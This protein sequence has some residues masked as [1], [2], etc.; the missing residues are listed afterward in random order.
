MIKISKPWIEIENNMV[1]L[2]AEIEIPEEAVD[3]WKDFSKK[4]HYYTY[5][6]S[7]YKIE[8]NKFI[9]WYKVD[10]SLK[11]SFC[12][13]R[14][15]AFLVAI[16]YYAMITGQD[17]ISD[18]CISN[19]L[20]FNLNYILIPTL[21]NE[22][23]GYK[24]IFINSEITKKTYESE[25]NFVATGMSAG[26]DSLYTLYSLKQDYVKEDYKINM[27][28]FI[29]AGA[30]HYCP[31]LPK[32]TKLDKI[33]KEAERIHREK[34]ER[35]KKIADEE[36]LNLMNIESNISDLYQGQFGVTHIYR[37]MSCI[38]AMQKVFRKY[39]Y[40]SAGLSIESYKP[41]LKM[42]PAYM[43]Q[44]IIPIL[45]TENLEVICGGESRTRYTKTKE[46]CNYS[47][48]QNNLNVCG[49]EMN[50]TACTK[51]YRT[52]LTL[53]QLGKLNEFSKVFDLKKYQRNRI[54][55]YIWLLNNSKKDDFAEDIYNHM[56]I[57][58]NIPLKAKLLA[59]I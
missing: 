17:V 56:K 45:S 11:D 6:K 49:K 31:Y 1:Y 37:N 19:K 48:A 5:I 36:K 8:N 21:C 52:L 12:D 28:T 41:D 2:K 23:S 26:I 22:Y 59:P 44:M 15:D 38:L 14:N 20:L 29:N 34:Y 27:L 54:K 7:D 10:K 33:N 32:E 51:C 47:V 13:D 35:A 58:K 53:E 18:C 9:L 42:D 50:C 39:Y 24:R 4:V 55:A 43:E 57:K 30:S 40:S 25:M 16:L 46:I 3:K